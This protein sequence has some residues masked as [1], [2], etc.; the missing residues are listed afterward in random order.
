[1]KHFADNSFSIKNR[2]IQEISL[3][4]YGSRNE[5]GYILFHIGKMA[6]CGLCSEKTMFHARDQLCSSLN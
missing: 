4:D 1:M 5:K 6:W 2:N 3:I